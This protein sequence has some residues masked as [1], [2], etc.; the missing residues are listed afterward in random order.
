LV[1]QKTAFYD[2]SQIMNT[3][4]IYPNLLYWIS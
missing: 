3:A 2:Q 4:A 1:K